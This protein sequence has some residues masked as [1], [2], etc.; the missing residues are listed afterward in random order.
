M[1]RT[2]GGALVT[3]LA[4]STHTRARMVRIDL[5]DGSTIAVTDHD[6]APV[7]DLGDGSATYSPRTG[8]I[9]SDLALSTGFDSDDV[10]ISG[11][12]VET[13]TEAWH[14]TRAAVLGGRFDD[15]TVRFFEVNWASL[16]S[17]AIRL[18]KGFVAKSDVEG[19]KFKLTVHSEIS[20]FKQEIGRTITAYCD[21]DFGD[22]RCG[23]AVTP[24]AATVTSVTDATQF[25]VSFTGTYADDYFNQGTVTFTSGALNGTRPIEIFD[26]SAAGQVALFME[27]AEAPEVGDTLDLRQGCGKTRDA[28]MAYDNIINFRGFPDVPGTDQV[29]RYPN[30]TSG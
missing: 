13:A 15:A 16:G 24:V 4:S 18:M 21:A 14:V 23:Y 29:L 25:T 22:S 8:I 20:R 27:A 28:C 10:E 7:F 19:S 1:S 9:A 2:L 3:H 5:K 12:I 6:R 30:P 26:W 11:P 17:G